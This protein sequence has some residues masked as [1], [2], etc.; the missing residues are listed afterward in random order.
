MGFY[1]IW[2]ELKIVDEPTYKEG[3]VFKE[4]SLFTAKPGTYGMKTYPLGGKNMNPEYF[5]IN[6]RR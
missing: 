6:P 3:S 5:S 4:T 2:D 1:G